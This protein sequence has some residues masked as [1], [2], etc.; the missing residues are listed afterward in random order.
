MSADFI[1][2]RSHFYQY[3]FVYSINNPKNLFF[4]ITNKLDC[5]IYLKAI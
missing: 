5:F 3:L 4:K 1:Y 2:P